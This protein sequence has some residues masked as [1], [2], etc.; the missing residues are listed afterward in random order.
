[1]SKILER[2]PLPDFEICRIL[3][4]L[5]EAKLLFVEPAGG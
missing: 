5:L 2:C 3:L 4:V 1:V